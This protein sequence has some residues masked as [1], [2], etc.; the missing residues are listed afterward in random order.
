MPTVSALTGG[1][2]AVGWAVQHGDYLVGQC[3]DAAGQPIGARFQAASAS[4]F[5]AIASA[6]PQDGSFLL[7]WTAST[8][9]GDVVQARRYAADGTSLGP[10]FPVN[11]RPPIFPW[12]GSVAGLE[13][14]GFV[15]TWSDE[16]SE[17]EFDRDVIARRFATD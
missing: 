7:M 17:E 8:Q 16:E 13:D 4:Y 14:G 12:D 1:G 9:E 11:S 6:G 10:S 2:F 15:A 3:F 5:D